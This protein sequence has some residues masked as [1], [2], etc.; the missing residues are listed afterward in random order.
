MKPIPAIDENREFVT[1]DGSGLVVATAAGRAALPNAAPLPRGAAL[2]RFW[3]DR[4]PA[5]EREVLQ[6]LIKSY[7]RAV[8][9]ARIDELTGY[10]RSSRDAYLQRLSAKE[11]V[12]DAGRGEVSAAKDLFG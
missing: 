1:V 2:Q 12:A 11:L 7:P 9:R 6:V 5:G 4:L 8:P 3:L 10:K